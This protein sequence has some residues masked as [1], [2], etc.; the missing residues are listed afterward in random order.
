MLRPLRRAPWISLRRSMRWRSHQRGNS[1]K[2][3]R[4]GETLAEASEERELLVKLYI[5]Y[6]CGVLY[7]YICILYITR[8]GFFRN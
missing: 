3:R 2:R 5:R 8:S 1:W 4:C 7:I 6:R